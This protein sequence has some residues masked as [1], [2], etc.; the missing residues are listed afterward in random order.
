[1]VNTLLSGFKV[2]GVLL[3]NVYRYVRKG[4]FIWRVEEKSL[5]KGDIVFP[6]MK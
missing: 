1:M 4:K 2:Q 3:H 6:L 5:V